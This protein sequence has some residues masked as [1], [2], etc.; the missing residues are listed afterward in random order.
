MQ[1]KNKMARKNWI[2]PHLRWT[3]LGVMASQCVTQVTDLTNMQRHPFFP[4]GER[5][6]F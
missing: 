5:T 3:L 1:S 4:S 6:D 2:D